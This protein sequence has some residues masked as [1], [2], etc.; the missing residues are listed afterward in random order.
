MQDL[1]TNI[2]IPLVSATIGGLAGGYAGYRGALRVQNREDRERCKAAGRALL[3]EMIKNYRALDYV[4][5]HRPAGFTETVLETELPLVARLLTWKELQ[6]VLEPYLLAAEPL[7]GF[8][9]AEDLRNKTRAYQAAG[10]HAVNF[11]RN[12]QEVI[13]KCQEELAKVREKFACAAEV[14]RHN[15][16]DEQELQDFLALSKGSIGDEPHGDSTPSV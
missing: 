15:V 5:E 16:L 4:G 2:L 9:V 10:N 12:A 13:K 6:T 11:E 8:S 14:L 7:Y 1:V 3:A